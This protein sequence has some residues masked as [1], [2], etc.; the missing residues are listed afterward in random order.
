MCQRYDSVTVPCLCGYLQECDEERE[1]HI[2]DRV[3]G[4]GAR[5]PGIFK[6]LIIR[7]VAYPIVLSQADIHTHIHTVIPHVLV[8]V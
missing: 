4:R 7:Q 6:V 5:G 3:E 2:E 8:T 1:K